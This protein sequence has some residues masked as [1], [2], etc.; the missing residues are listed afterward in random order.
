MHQVMLRPLIFKKWGK[1]AAELSG[2][3]L[4]RWHVFFSPCKSSF[5]S[6]SRHYAYGNTTTNRNHDSVRL[7]PDL[8]H[9]YVRHGIHRGTNPNTANFHGHRR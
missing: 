3:P 7:A 4:S 6:V 2:W 8:Y 1:G 5:L 9:R